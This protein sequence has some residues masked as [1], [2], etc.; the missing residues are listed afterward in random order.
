MAMLKNVVFTLFLASCLGVLPVTA[1]L[2]DEGNSADVSGWQTDYKNIWN[3]NAY[4]QKESWESYWSWVRQFFLG[5]L[6]DRGWFSEHGRYTAG[7][8]TDPT[9]RDSIQAELTKLGRGIAAEWSKPNSCRKIDTKLL[10]QWY[11]DLKMPAARD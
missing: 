11:A 1:A 6:L 2:A 5:N 7:K 9:K 10:E 3:A 8:I 4:A